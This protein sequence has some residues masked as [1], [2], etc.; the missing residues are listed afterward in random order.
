MTAQTVVRKLA[1]TDKIT[2]VLEHIKGERYGKIRVSST[3]WDEPRVVLEDQTLDARS[4]NGQLR[5][6]V[7]ER[8][9]DEGDP[10]PV[11]SDYEPY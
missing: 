4:V 1:V 10:V 6:A 7:K 5:I 11:P 3:S 9:H 8:V 2:V